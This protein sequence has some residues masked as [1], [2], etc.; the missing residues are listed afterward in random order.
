[1]RNFWQKITESQTSKAQS[2]KR[3]YLE[4]EIAASLAPLMAEMLRPQGFSK[5][6]EQLAQSFFQKQFPSLDS[7]PIF[8]SVE[9]HITLGAQPMLKICCKHLQGLMDEESCRLVIQF[10]L[11]LAS[12]D[13]FIHARKLRLTH[14]IATYLNVSEQDFLSIKTKF[15]TQ[16]NPYVILET[17]PTASLAEVK[18]AYRRMVLKFHPD[19]RPANISEHEANEKFLQIQ[20]A[21]QA[22]LNGYEME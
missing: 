12:A 8:N 7:K 3:V 15:L 6:S 4:K 5:T 9:N 20:A 16:N 18:K 14:R 22:I 13:D 17:D 1:M 19:K 21:F 10:L 2:N 11:S